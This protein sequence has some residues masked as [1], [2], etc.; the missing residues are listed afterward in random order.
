[1]TFQQFAKKW[2]EENVPISAVYGSFLR[3]NL[4][5]FVD[6]FNNQGHSGASAT[7]F[8]YMLRNLLN[9]YLGE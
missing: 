1:M 6:L 8:L 7:Q 3:S 9:D 5:E 4:L 2:I